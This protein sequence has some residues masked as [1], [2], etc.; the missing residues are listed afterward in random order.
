MCPGVGL[1]DGAE[2]APKVPELQPELLG[3]P[4]DSGHLAANPVAVCLWGLSCAILQALQD[5]LLTMSSCGWRG[6]T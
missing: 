6:G 2:L 3:L 4:Q 5:V 1:E